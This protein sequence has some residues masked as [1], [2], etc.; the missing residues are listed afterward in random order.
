MRSKW[1]G[2]DMQLVYQDWA[3]ALHDC[4]LGAIDFAITKSKLC[5]H[6]PSQGEFKAL[7]KDYTPPVDESML[8][9]KAESTITKEQAMENLAKI[10]S[11][12]T[13]VCS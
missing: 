12:L 9:G 6:P 4:S 13:G 8:I 5:T 3:E 10:K 2:I 11:M 7:S 1:D